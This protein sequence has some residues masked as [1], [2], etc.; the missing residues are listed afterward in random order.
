MSA[1]LLKLR[2][3]MYS[4]MALVIGLSTL[5][6]TSVFY[7]LSPSAG[8]NVIIWGSLIFIIFA[9]IIQWLLGPAIIEAL[10]RVKPVGAEMAWLS[11]MVRN[12]SYSSGLKEPPKTMIANVDVPNAFAYG[13]LLSGYKVAVTRGLINNLP[14]EEVEAVI[15][16][17][18]GHIKHRDV[19][20]MMV[21]S[22]LP[23]LIYWLGQVLVRYGFI[24]GAV[25][26]RRNG[27]SSPLLLSAFGFA[28]LIISFLFNLFVLYLSRL[29]EYYSDSHAAT[30]VQGGALKLQRA[31]ARILVVSDSFR[32]IKSSELEQITKFKALLISDPEIVV[33][34]R[35]FYSIDE[36]V[37]YI[38]SSK[39]ISMLEVFSTHPD[40]AK[41][42]RFLDRFKYT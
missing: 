5:I 12:L 24:S 42:L 10:Y 15:A 33:G 14:R 3:S 18:I 23:A 11:D 26:D 8:V 32:R 38:K 13:N 20:V 27:R 37:E 41:R 9:H 35:R 19:E 7:L 2:L 17:E 1:T 16:H 6:L 34:G 31:L 36:V 30:T 28:L 25:G 21:V 22:I 40:P 29:R 39:S 4:V